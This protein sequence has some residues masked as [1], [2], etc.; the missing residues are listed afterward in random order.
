MW[1]A[2]SGKIL[3]LCDYSKEK[4]DI[5]LPL[6]KEVLKLNRFCWEV[7]EFFNK[8]HDSVVVELQ[9]DEPKKALLKWFHFYGFGSRTETIEIP[10]DVV[11][12]IHGKCLEILNDKCE[13]LA[14]MCGWYKEH[15]R[16]EEYTK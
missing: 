6:A 1:N 12:V 10:E 9:K 13:G 14:E 8:K 4:F 11:W 3:E 5:E 2:G 15:P 16:D 7:F